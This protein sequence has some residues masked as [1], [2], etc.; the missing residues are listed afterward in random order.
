MS[1]RHRNRA[2]EIV[3]RILY[4]TIAT[5]SS[6][7]EPWNSPVYSAYDDDA[8]FYW[9][10]SPHAQHSRN[11]DDNGKAFLVIYDSTAPEGTGEGVYVEA[12]AAAL[13]DPA[14]IAE[15][16]RNLA[17]RV[18]KQL[19]PEPDRLLEA[20]VQRIYRATPKRVWMNGFEHDANGSFVR[21]IRVEI[22]IACLEGL[23]TW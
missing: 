8:N 19:G 23:V 13:E 21:D 7:V 20:G 16:R 5:A 14:E 6:K 2:R 9:T 4:V 17:L 12:T 11:I 22:P 1:E 3:Q 15:A 10:S 18:R